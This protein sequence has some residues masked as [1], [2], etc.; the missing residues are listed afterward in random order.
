MK[1][2]K[3]CKALLQTLHQFL[4][5]HS[6]QSKRMDSSITYFLIFNVFLAKV[7]PLSIINTEKWVAILVTKTESIIGHR[8]GC[9]FKPWVEIQVRWVLRWYGKICDIY[10]I[11]SNS[12][13]KDW[14]RQP[15][16]II[17][18]QSALETAGIS[19][20]LKG[21]SLKIDK[22]ISFLRKAFF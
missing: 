4:E 20:R 13:S 16:N 2:S 9:N 17:N 14:S 7:F 3:A 8:I 1:Y 10:Q 12:N 18:A 5:N 22:K 6:Q 21:S 15:R 11:I 19:K